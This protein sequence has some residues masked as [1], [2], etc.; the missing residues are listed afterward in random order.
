[1]YIYTFSYKIE[2]RIQVTVYLRGTRRLSENPV[3]IETILPYER[4]VYKQW[5]EGKRTSECHCFPPTDDRYIIEG[6]VTYYRL[7]LRWNTAA[8]EIVFSRNNPKY[9]YRQDWARS[10]DTDQMPQ[11]AASNSTL[12]ADHTAIFETHHWIVEWTIS[13]F[14]T[15]MVS[16]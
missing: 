6:H 2:D 12:F 10:V 16:R 14:R 3:T 1:M 9:W 8:F 11:N 4:K 13:N 5:E 7:D 15:S